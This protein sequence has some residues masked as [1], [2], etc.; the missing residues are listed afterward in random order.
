M[1]ATVWRDGDGT[2]A[3]VK[4]AA[5]SGVDVDRLVSWA[6]ATLQAPHRAMAAQRSMPPQGVYVA[7]FDFGSPATRFGLYPGQ[8][9]VEVDGTPTP[10][11]DSFITGSA[12]APT[13]A[14]C[15]SRPWAGT[16]RP[17]SSR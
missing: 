13:A 6:G 17:R 4:T 1:Q 15:A 5:L 7:Y 8:R 12:A 11:L 10:D 9:I 3:A 14:R 2:D 16:T